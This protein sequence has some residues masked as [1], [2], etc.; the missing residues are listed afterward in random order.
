MS[1]ENSFWLIEPRDALIVRDGRPFGRDAG[2]RADSLEFPFPSTTTGAVRTRAG[3]SVID[4]DLSK[5]KDH[6]IEN[7]SLA[8]FVQENIKVSGAILAEIKIGNE[9]E[10]LVPAPADAVLFE[11]KKDG[12]TDEDRAKIIPLLPLETESEGKFF[13]NLN[14]AEEKLRL[15][16]LQKNE[17]EKPHKNAPKFW[18][19]EKFVEWLKESKIP[20]NQEPKI[21]ELKTLGIGSLEKDRRTHVE[22]DYGKKSGKDGGLFETRGLEFTHKI[23]PKKADEK[24]EF[25]RYGFLLRV[26]S[27][28]F[29]GKIENGIAPLGGERRLVSWSKKNEF[30]F[31]KCEIQIGKYCR[32]ILLTPAYFEEGFLPTFLTDACGAKCKIEAIA[33]TRSQVVS[34]WDFKKH[35]PKPTRR[36]CPAGTV[37]FIKFDDEETAENIEKWKQNVWF[38]CISDNCNEAN[39]DQYR[40][41]G[42]GL[43]VFGNWDGKYLKLED[44]VK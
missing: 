40:K 3:L 18:R 30:V 16:G 39:A 44:V 20:D 9:V 11:V 34:G 22:M 24:L 17:K 36:L 10:L 42:F 23:E 14:E 5:F 15:L 28:N 37:I 29:N 38:N 41:D 25:K 26:E 4:N 12:K 27:D 43:A 7:K 2:N 19:W 13:S 33:V 32:V 21:C 35:A 31:P 1:K 6:R 8:D